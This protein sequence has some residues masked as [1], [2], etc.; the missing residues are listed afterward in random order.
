[1]TTEQTDRLAMFDA[2]H[3]LLAGSTETAGIPAFAARFA[4]FA[5]KRGQIAV[6]EAQQ[7]DPL[8]S[9]IAIRDEALA[10]MIGTTLALAGA[11]LSF[12]N[13]QELESLALKVRFTPSVF[14][15]V[16]LAQK[17]VFAQ[18]I[19]DAVKTV[20]P[21]PGDHG[22]TAER[23]TSAQALIAEA[24]AHVA[25]S[26]TTVAAK[27]AATERLTTVFRE[28][29]A[30]LDS[31]LD[32]LLAPL[33]ETKPEFYARY[34]AVREIVA[35]PATRATANAATPAVTPTPSTVNPTA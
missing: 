23:V 21:L 18:H 25:A 32:P 22:I 31:Q 29:N 14:D 5:T 16:R 3:A 27:R 11:V 13:A 9:Q 34:R 15:R 26:R 19:L 6:L 7:T 17:A 1:M 8:R 33:E 35:R 4:T 10:A 24:A 20:L 12:A 30:V 2:T 28:T